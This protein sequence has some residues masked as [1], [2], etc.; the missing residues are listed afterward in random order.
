MS[1]SLI[2]S[3]LFSHLLIQDLQLSHSVSKSKGIPSCMHFKN[4]CVNTDRD[5]AMIFSH[6]FLSVFTR[7][8]YVFSTPSTEEE[9]PPTE[10]LSTILKQ[11]SDVYDALT[12]LNPH[13]S[14][15]AGAIG[16]IDLSSCALALYEPLI[17]FFS[18]TFSQESLPKTGL[19]IAS[20]LYTR[21]VIDT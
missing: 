3:E 6:Y 19:L 13:K 2:C 5:K 14:M 12:S 9:P 20:F 11:T 16:P 15:D 10:T 17:C 1:L 4:D 7:D 8:S 18:L 21:K